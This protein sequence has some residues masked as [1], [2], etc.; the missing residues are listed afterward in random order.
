MESV[1]RYE[2]SN[3][4]EGLQKFI[5]NLEQGEDLATGYGPVMYHVH[6]NEMT[7]LEKWIHEL[8]L[9]VSLKEMPVP[10]WVVTEIKETWNAACE[11]GSQLAAFR[12]FERMVDRIGYGRT[13]NNPSLVSTE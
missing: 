9:S 4:G 11:A 12:I 3:D 6:S 10:G 7:E 8:L 2:L 1:L 13:E 5:R